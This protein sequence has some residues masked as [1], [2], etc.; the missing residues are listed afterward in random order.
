MLNDSQVSEIPS[1]F[2]KD[3]IVDRQQV[4][5]I[6]IIIKSG[7]LKHFLNIQIRTACFWENAWS[8][9]CLTFRCTSRSPIFR[10]PTWHPAFSPPSRGCRWTPC[11]RTRGS[12]HLKWHFN[13]AVKLLKALSLH[14]LNMSKTLSRINKN[15]NQFSKCQPLLWL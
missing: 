5:D 12:V 1:K 13:N 7:Y 10:R 2:N 4:V 3:K 9:F 15:L 14:A 11:C 8:T 6:N